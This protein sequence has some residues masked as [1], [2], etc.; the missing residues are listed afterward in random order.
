M[1]RMRQKRKARGEAEQTDAEQTDADNVEVIEPSATG[2]LKNIVE[3]L[4]FAAD[5]P[6]DVKEI[7]RLCKERKI[8]RVEEALAE[9]MTEYEE[10][11]IV[12][13]NVAGGYQFRTNPANSAWVTQ[14]VAGRPVRLTRAQLETLAIVAY[15]QP[16]TRP[17]IEEIRG[18]DTGSSIHI[19][20]ERALIRI[21]G[22]K[23]E[24]GR[25]MLYG[26]T[27]TFLEF[28]NLNELRDLPTLREFHELTEDS[29]REVER[30]GMD[31]EA[32][33]AESA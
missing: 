31:V 22:K 29:K 7:K 30:L 8:A 2:R 28:F 1:T 12:L 21:I 26:T 6:L 10:R 33:E 23:E 16:I 20:L 4:L 19:L 13:H 3:S 5:K 17:E 27:R 25:P 24:P 18:V 32:P 15:R 11:G 9:L 14:L